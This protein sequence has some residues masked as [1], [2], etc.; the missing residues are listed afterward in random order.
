MREKRVELFA[1]TSKIIRRDRNIVGKFRIILKEDEAKDTCQPGLKITA[2]Q[3]TMSSLIWILTGQT[4][5]LK[6]IKN[7]Q[8]KTGYPNIS[9]FFSAF[10][11]YS[12]I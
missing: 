2:S 4:V 6:V 11:N 12:C 7:E 10:L 1:L 5:V 8:I 9:S 3:Q